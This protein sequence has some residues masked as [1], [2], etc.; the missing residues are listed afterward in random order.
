MESQPTYCPQC[1]K[2]VR[3]TWTS[4]VAHETHA[5]IPDG[6]KLLCFDVGEDCEGMICPLSGNSTLL[7]GVRLARSGE[8]P[9]EVWPHDLLKCRGCGRKTGMEVLDSGHAFC[10]ICGTT[11][12]RKI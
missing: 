1:D 7:M 2:T 9:Y 6:G 5:T 12:T 11:N 10:P 3:V 4:S 8:V